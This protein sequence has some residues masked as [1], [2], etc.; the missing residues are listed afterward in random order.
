MN[1]HT[2]THYHVSR[3]QELSASL[4]SFSLI[5]RWWAQKQHLRMKMIEMYQ[6]VH[7]R[8]WDFVHFSEFSKLFSSSPPSSISPF[9]YIFPVERTIKKRSKRNEMML[10][11]YKANINIFGFLDFNSMFMLL[12]LN[13][14]YMGLVQLICHSPKKFIT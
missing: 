10:M 8:I 4:L 5:L 6:L 9:P 3:S 12:N 11:V 2:C 13:K 14:W 1:T 7:K